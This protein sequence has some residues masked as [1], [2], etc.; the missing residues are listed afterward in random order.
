MEPTEV[1]VKENE[2]N[3]KSFTV[4]RDASECLEEGPAAIPMML[5][6]I[7]A[8]KPLATVDKIVKFAESEG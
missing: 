2:I 5:M 6:S 4:Y 1:Y 7:G 3:N 8:Y